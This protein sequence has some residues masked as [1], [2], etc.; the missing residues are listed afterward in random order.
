MIHPARIYAMEQ[1]NKLIKLT[2]Q[3]FFNHVQ[4]NYYPDQDISFMEYFL[5][6]TQHEGEFVVPHNKLLEFGIMTSTRSS[7]ILEKLEQLDLENEVDYLLQDILQPVKQ[8][9]FTKSK[10]Y[11][12]TPEAFKLC[13]MSAKKYPGQ[14]VN[15]LVYRKYYILLEKVFK[16]YTD[17]EREYS[18]CIMAIKDD[19]IDRMA[20]DIKDLI[21]S[22][23]DLKCENQ[24]LLS[25]S[26]LMLSQNGHLITQVSHLNNKIDAMFE[27]ML[28]FA[29]MTIPTWIGSSVIKQQYDTLATNKT[30]KYAL[31]HLKVMYMVGFYIKE[32]RLLYRTKTIGDDTIRFPGRGRMIVYACCTNFSDISARLKLL[33]TRHASDDVPEDERMCMMRPKII[34]LISCEINSERIILENAT[35]IFPKQSIATWDGKYKSFELIIATAHYSN[36]QNIFNDFCKKAVDLRFQDYQQRIDQFGQTT[37][38]KVDSKIISYIDK[39]DHEFFSSTRPFA[40]KFIDRYVSK[41]SHGVTGTTL[42]YAYIVPSRSREIRDDLNGANLTTNAY[43]LQKIKGL[44]F[45]HTSKDHIEYMTT[46]GLLSKN[47]LPALRAIAEYENIDVSA[48]EA[49]YSN[50]LDEY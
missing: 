28:S 39:V 33:Y 31:D 13:L 1:A 12:L 43:A 47:D 42:T 19:K 17:Y 15:P 22:N 49:E 40:Q 50:E 38:V 32:A 37:E 6:L 45:E 5:D 41:S 46:N 3:E 4:S 30:S 10:Q 7:V 25:N 9:G 16:L 27:F 2:M 23:K 18:K 21:A 11:M 8:G 26:R 24:E 36:A 44:L 29:R 35:G 20:N 34:T 14:M 48:L